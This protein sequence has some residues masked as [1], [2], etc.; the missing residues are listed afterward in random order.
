MFTKCCAGNI[1]PK[2]TDYEQIHCN[3]IY[4]RLGGRKNQAKGG[5]S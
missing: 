4:R 3:P 5:L 2:E 1:S